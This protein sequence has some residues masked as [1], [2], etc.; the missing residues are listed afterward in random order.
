MDLFLIQEVLSFF[1]SKLCFFVSG[2]ASVMEPLSASLDAQVLCLQYKFDNPPETIEDLAKSL[3]IVSEIFN[4]PHF[5]KVDPPPL[6][7]V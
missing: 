7:D 1:K 4:K 5:L 6:R 3:L 2:V